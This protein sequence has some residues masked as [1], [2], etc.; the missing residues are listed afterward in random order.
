MLI[1]VSASSK[2]LKKSWS[3]ILYQLRKKVAIWSQLNLTRKR[4]IRNRAPAVKKNCGFLLPWVM[5]SIN[6]C[7]VF[8]FFQRQHLERPQIL[9]LQNGHNL[10]GK[11]NNNNNKNKSDTSQES[12]QNRT[13]LGQHCQFYCS[14]INEGLLLRWQRNTSLPPESWM[15]D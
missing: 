13:V 10:K 11:W 6:T 3:C 15:T 1:F 5:Q 9:K 8:F 7:G 12:L 14:E 2:C 4:L